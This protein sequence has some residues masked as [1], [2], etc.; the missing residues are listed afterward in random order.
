MARDLLSQIL[1]KKSDVK[2]PGLKVTLSR[3]KKR[4]DLKSIDQ[5]AC[6]Y[7]KKNNL[8]INVSSIIDDVTRKAV[9]DEF[10]SENRP[11]PAIKISK[12]KQNQKPLLKSDDPFVDNQTFNAAYSNAEIY[13]IIYL[14]ENSVRSFIV[15]VMKKDFGDS[16]WTE[17]V[18]K[19]NTRIKE[20]VEIR[21]LAEKEAPWHSTRGADPI[22]YTDI[23][24]LKK[25]LNTY[26]KE[27]RKIL[28]G[29]FEHVIVWIDEIEK[30]RNTLA[31]NNPVT[32]R[33]RDRLMLYA[34]DWGKYV[35][36]IY[37]ELRKSEFTS[38]KFNSSG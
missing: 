21:R 13:P 32:K 4:L 31:H 30:T 24:D 18:E 29:K 36:Y 38:T 27:F 34:H 2:R 23:D 28:K 11:N 6:F 20:N 3:I 10:A 9:Q 7:I 5:A 33:D 14:F 16:W 15:A 25:I 1:E 17:K 22:Y 37:E 26:S 12:R 8:D 35:N 19:V